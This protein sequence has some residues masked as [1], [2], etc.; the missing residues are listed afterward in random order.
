MLDVHGKLKTFFGY[1]NFRTYNDGE[2]LQENAVRA[3]VDGRS[4]LAVFP[5]GGGK[6]LT[7]QL[8]ALIAG[9]TAHGLTIVISPLQSLMKDQVDNLAA[10]GIVDAV[11]INGLLNPIERSEAIERVANG[12]ASILYI[13]PE[14]LRSNTI[15]RLLLSR[16]IARFVIDEAHCFSAWGHDFRVDY[17]YI[18]DFIKN[19]QEKKRLPEP[20]PV[21]CFTATA[22]QK[23]ISDVRDYFQEK[24][25]LNLEIFATDSTRKNLHY[26]VLY[27]ETDE[28]K[29]DT[30]RNLI[31][32]KNCP[33]IVYVSRTR[34]SKELAER[35]TSDGFEALPFNGKMD[36]TE[37]IVNQEAFIN[38]KVKV[39]VATSAFGMGVDKPD[40]KL[41]VHYDISDS[42]E[43]YVQ[44]SG[45]AGRD[46]SLN[47]ECYVL[48]ND[49]DLDKHF[50]LLNQTKLS[51]SEI[52]Q[53]WKA[54]KTMT[55]TRAKI[56]CS[57]LEIS[58]QAGWDTTGK[59][60]ETRVKT[61]V[62]A[63]E[64]AGYI[65]RGNNVPHIYASGIRVKNM[66]EAVAKIDESN[67]LDDTQ[68]VNSK[69][70]IKSL[71]SARSIATATDDDAES[72]VDYL[73]DTLGID[74]SDVIFCINLMRQEGILADS[75]DMSAYI[76]GN[77]SENK[78]LTNLENFARLED[79]VLK[80]IVCDD[81]YLQLK[82]LNEIAALNN[83]T[84]SSVK[85][86]RTI[87]Y[88][89]TIKGLIKK[90]ENSNNQCVK[91][92]VNGEMS[93]LREKFRKRIEI[94]RFVVKEL[95]EKTKLSAERNDNFVAVN[96]SL[97]EL[98]NAFKKQSV[99]DFSVTATKQ[100]DIEDALLYLSKI[101]AMKLEGGFLVLYNGLEIK[102]LV[103]DNKVR[104]KQD[105]YKSMDQFY[106]QRIQQIH[107]V[108]EYAHLMV[109]DYPTALK[110]V[111]DYFQLDFKR[112]ISKYFKAERAKQ[113][114][115]NI[116]PVKYDQI[117]GTLSEKQLQ[118][119][120]DSES[121]HIVVAAGPGSGKTM[122]LVHKL[123]ALLLMEDI[124]HEQML[125]LTFSRAAAT[126]FKKR[127]I[128]LIGNAANF[129]EIKTFHS[130]CFDLLGKMGTL[131]NAD[132]VVK[133]A[134]DLILNNGVEINRIT[135][136]VLVIDEAQDMDADEFALVQALMKSND[137]MRVIAV[138]DDD[139][140][141][142]QFRKSDS[143]F[144][145]QLVTDYDA[146]L[147]EM[148]DNYRSRPNIVAISNAVVSQIRFRMKTHPIQAVQTENG[149]VKITLHAS[150]NME[151]A[152]V[153]QILEA[154]NL[155]KTCILTN[156]NDDALQLVGTLIDNGLRA[157]LIQTLDS[158]DLF[159]LAEIR[160]FVKTL[161]RNLTTPLINAE[162]WQNAKEQL[163]QK[164]CGSKC[165][166]QCMNLI[167]SFESV[168]TKT[169]YRT[170][171]EEFIRESRLE[172]FYDDNT[173]TITVS[174]IHKAKGREFD[175]VIL[176]LKNY[177]ATSDEK[178][179][180]LYVGMT[181]AKK[182][183]F[184]HCNSF[185]FNELPNCSIEREFDN[186][187]YEEPSTVTYQL[188]HRDVFLSFFKERKNQI[189][190]LKSGDVLY[191][192]GEMLLAHIDGMK[193]PILK[194]SKA[195]SDVLQNRVNQGFSMVSAEIRFIVAW[196]GKDDDSETAV[197][198]PS[199]T[200][201]RK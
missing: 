174:T 73:A 43:N 106:K 44:E 7:F 100:S 192:D 97:L 86:I 144:M 112:F 94:C 21:S 3:A 116:T 12:M 83:I 140:N 74:K 173:E 49:N 78:A 101:G 4:L 15:E 69:R 179:R 118:I 28:E 175:T 168:N 138:G 6:S 165:L 188:T 9:E 180:C 193:I 14:Q 96:F 32:Q 122:L 181:R 30:L 26:V 149:I 142:Y 157:K 200:L 190:K 103:K 85:N 60:V 199:V 19:L 89:L 18:G 10:R 195:F 141:V 52:Q 99:L 41:V 93:V 194:Y 39:M 59:D 154:G 71:I 191:P 40:I 120:N 146:V 27:K 23:V 110:F 156:T 102:K 201:E 121:K 126:E 35:L 79:F 76:L 56:C 162:T 58:R 134:T 125:M 65:K 119:V 80:N 67:L 17:L 178:I 114:D 105:D 34:K 11:T 25:S 129:V 87:L 92:T 124:K 37:K 54:I 113:I 115:R 137:D 130:Y 143:R 148:N 68:K 63:L 16:N 150:A 153:R 55:K 131:E 45:R 189:L 127:L 133:D 109:K 81:C 108:G 91:V 111:Q 42:L 64:Q 152:V 170:D 160:Y 77:E 163:A 5:T 31:E 182:Q 20:I 183:L 177:D 136:K 197:I 47:A 104:Y 75:L 62:A 145:R 70:I 46:Q 185:I 169:M 117:F 167:H 128:S 33:T 51:F 57:P 8:P 161:D 36:P 2:P 95:Y 61:A 98:L 184:I 48:F 53:V 84:I 159:D 155:G 166:E 147:Y 90:E 139:Q 158:F 151:M 107:I 176:M 29:Y 164:Y 196:K 123:A 1:D 82:K 88:F 24:L 22:K 38:N 135:K 172:D 198:L 186:V 171:L 13:S 72:R 50:L 132:N 187:Q 66:D